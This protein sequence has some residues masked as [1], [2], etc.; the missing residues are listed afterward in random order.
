MVTLQRIAEITAREQGA[1]KNRGKGI[2]LNLFIRE[3]LR[4]THPRG[5]Y[6]YHIFQEWR[7][8]NKEAGYRKSAS[9]Q[10]VR[11][12][13]YLIK[14]LGLVRTTQVPATNEMTGARVMRSYYTLVA[15]KVRDEAWLNPR[16]ILYG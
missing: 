13:L 3:R 10:S 6:P 8:V 16:R 15:N 2:S 11:Q 9:Y 5:D 1:T 4:E 12:A 7:R 14:R